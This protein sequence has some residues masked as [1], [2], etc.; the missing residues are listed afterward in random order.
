VL[1]WRPA[2]VTVPGRLL[3]PGPEPPVL[4]QRAAG[5]L[6]LAQALPEQV[7]VPPRAALLARR[8]Q[9]EG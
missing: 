5:A 1:A 7:L 8:P 6:W 2:L 3:G 9:S 4:A